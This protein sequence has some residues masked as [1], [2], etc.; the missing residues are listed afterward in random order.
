M[1]IFMYFVG[2]VFIVIGLSPFIVWFY[3]APYNQVL[4]DR[5]SVK[6]SVWKEVVGYGWV[7]FFVVNVTYCYTVDDASYS[8]NN[9]SF[10]DKLKFYSEARCDRFIDSINNKKYCFYSIKK[11][12]FSVLS[13]LYTAGDRSSFAAMFVIGII[14]IFLSVFIHYTFG[15][16]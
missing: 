12:S 13:K 9:V 16:N 15:F 4:I 8:G 2:L 11:P 10:S 7:D 3:Y 5:I 6:K 14:F 1:L